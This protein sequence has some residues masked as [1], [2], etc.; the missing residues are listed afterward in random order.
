MKEKWD[1]DYQGKKYPC[2][3]TYKAMRSL[4][5]RFDKEGTTFLVNCPYGTDRDYLEKA[6]MKYFPRL[7]KKVSYEQPIQGDDF[8]FFGVKNHQDGFKDL[9]EK[10]QDKYLKKALLDYLENKVPYYESLMGIRKP[11]KVRVRKMSTRYGVNSKK[12]YSLTF[13]LLLVHY[14]PAIIDSVVVHEL[15]HHFVFNHSK[16]FYEKLYAYYPNYDL[17]HAKL[18]K[19]SYE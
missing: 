9:D 8:Y 2:V 14:S 4:R 12:T 7:M 13:A 1:I 5:F 18:R 15:A 16:A 3:I 6:V 11:Y 10:A 19:H 17:N